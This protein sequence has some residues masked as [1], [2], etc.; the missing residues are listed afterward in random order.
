MKWERKD[1]GLV[2]GLCFGFRD[3]AVLLTI[4]DDYLFGNVCGCGSLT[5][6]MD[7]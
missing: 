1:L 6:P 3:M 4:P 2:T 7:L 5:F